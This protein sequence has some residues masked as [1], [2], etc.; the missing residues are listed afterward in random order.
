MI[1]LLMLVSG[2]EV[3]LASPLK[4]WLTLMEIGLMGLSSVLMW[5]L[6]VLAAQDQTDSKKNLDDSSIPGCTSWSNDY[7]WMWYRPH[8]YFQGTYV[9]PCKLDT[10]QIS[11]LR[12]GNRCNPDLSRVLG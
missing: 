3:V 12:H 6:L 2:L 10:P 4:I 1:L 7:N 11:G 9:K 5:K 8:S